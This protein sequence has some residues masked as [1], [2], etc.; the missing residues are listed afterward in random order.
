[1]LWLHERDT[2]DCR[3]IDAFTGLPPHIHSA[4][5]EAYIRGA[6]AHPIPE[7]DIAALTAPWL[8]GEGPAAF[9]RQFAQADDALTDAFAPRLGQQTCPVQVL[10]GADDPWIPLERGARLAHLLGDVPF[11]PIKGLGHLPQL[12]DPARVADHLL[13]AL[14]E[15]E[16]A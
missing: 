8:A 11:T 10:W 3:H 4:I 14:T 9:Y 1:M 13:T 7:E 6:L 16:A 15:R 5:V 12:E 2:I